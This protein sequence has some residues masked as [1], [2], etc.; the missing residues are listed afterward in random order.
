MCARQPPHPRRLDVADHRDRGVA[1]H[2]PAP[3]ERL[4]IARPQRADG[5]GAADHRPPVGVHH[6][7]GGE[8]LVQERAPGRVVVGAQLLEHHR[9]LAL[10]GVAVEPRERQRVA[11]GGEPDLEGGLGHR[12]VKH[13]VIGGGPGVDLAAEPLDLAGQGAAAVGAGAKHQVL[14]HVGDAGVVRGL[15]GGAGPDPGLDGDHGRGLDPLGGDG[16]AAVEV[17]EVGGD[18]AGGAPTEPGKK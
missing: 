2:V 5:G 16:D 4:E 13:G 14:E 1:G 12:E 10:E 8:H 18:H 9:A 6:E 7:R 3:E 15:V 17:V 11:E